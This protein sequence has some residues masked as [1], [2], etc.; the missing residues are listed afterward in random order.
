LAK[1]YGKNVVC[2]G[3][4]YRSMTAEGPRIRLEF[5]YADGLKSS[6]G[7]PLSEFTVA[8][9][10]RRFVAARA[11]I[12]GRSILVESPEV[13]HPAAARFAWREDAAPN[14]VNSA[15]LPA[16]P[17]RTDIGGQSP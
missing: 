9:P 3:P 12:D 13:P 14:F 8:G 6:D 5:D 10:D 2:S 4:I 16:S 17:F 15:G 1:D 11:T 7:E